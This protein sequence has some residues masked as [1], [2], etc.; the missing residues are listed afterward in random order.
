M[1]NLVKF[2]LFLLLS[3]TFVGSVNAMSDGSAAAAGAGEKRE[4]SAGEVERE[5]A[6]LDADFA[7]D[8]ARLREARRLYNQ[9]AEASAAAVKGIVD[10]R[11]AQELAARSKVAQELAARSK[12]SVTAAF[13]ERVRQAAKW[14][15]EHYVQAT[16][17][18]L[19]T[20]AVV[21][22][23]ATERGRGIVRDGA[24]AVRDGAVAAG[25]SV[26]NVVSRK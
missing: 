4:R 26:K 1:K 24:V 6:A 18:A 9:A 14:S 5:E 10:D 8:A 22:G 23:A 19:A 25:T 21:Y 7:R 3:M 12:K 11:A 20:G 13:S 2:P 15:K 17:G 16:V